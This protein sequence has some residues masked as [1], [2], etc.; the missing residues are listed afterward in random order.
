MKDSAKKEE[1]LHIMTQVFGGAG[2]EEKKLVKHIIQQVEVDKTPE[3]IV[4]AR[5]K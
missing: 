3:K 1:S 4:I 5:K 2:D